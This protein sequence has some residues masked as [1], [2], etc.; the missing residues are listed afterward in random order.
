MWQGVGGS[1]LTGAEWPVRT[2]AGS[3]EGGRGFGSRWVQTRSSSAFRTP[4]RRVLGGLLGCLMM[5]LLLV[6]VDFAVMILGWRERVFLG[7]VMVFDSDDDDD[8]GINEWRL[9]EEGIRVSIFVLGE[10]G[11]LALGVV[12]VSRSLTNV[13]WKPYGTLWGSLT[14][15]TISRFADLASMT[16]NR[17]S[18]TVSSCTNVTRYPSSSSAVGLSG[19]LGTKDGSPL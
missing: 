18:S 12:R 6:Q 16:K 11:K 9:V 7:L 14:T 17:D 10:F 15:A 4:A 5:I 2:R 3:I 13:P 8:D 19:S 1:S